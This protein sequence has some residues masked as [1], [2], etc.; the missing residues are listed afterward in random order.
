MQQTS[1]D[2]LAK[3]VKEFPALK[4]YIDPVRHDGV[5]M[6]IQVVVKRADT[7][8]MGFR[9]SAID[10]PACFLHRNGMVGCMFQE[11]IP[12][13][14]NDHLKIERFPYLHRAPGSIRDLSRA[15]GPDFSSAFFSVNISFFIA[16]LLIYVY[17]YV[18]VR[19]K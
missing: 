15:R 3:Q 13:H 2:I 19:I 18:L 7:E 14:R 12:V 17:L 11:V 6:T 1:P 8:F 10:G 4:G 5:P 16:K 9:P